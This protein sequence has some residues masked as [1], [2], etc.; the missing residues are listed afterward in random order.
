MQSTSANHRRQDTKN[1]NP[2]RSPVLEF[3]R[4]IWHSLNDTK[5]HYSVDQFLPIARSQTMIIVPI[6]LLYP[7]ITKEC[8]GARIL[9]CRIAFPWLGWDFRCGNRQ[10][11]RSGRVYCSCTLLPCKPV[12]KMPT[13]AL[14]EPVTLTLVRSYKCIEQQFDIVEDIRIVPPPRI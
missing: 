12:V 5:P 6:S 7:Q 8:Q 9:T 10:A 13:S 1:E 14:A 11:N 2:S 4:R 3:F